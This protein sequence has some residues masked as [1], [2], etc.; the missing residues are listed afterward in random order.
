MELKTFYFC[1]TTAKDF[2]AD[3]FVFLNK[4]NAIKIALKVLGE[5][6]GFIGY[7]Y[8]TLILDLER[9]KWYDGMSFLN[10]ITTYVS[11]FRAK[12]E[13]RVNQGKTIK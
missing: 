6:Q 13:F 12:T 7:V 3:N 10:C 2:P 4:V 8:R 5:S 11:V 9:R 1:E